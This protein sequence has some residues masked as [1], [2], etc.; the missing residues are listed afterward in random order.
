MMSINLPTPRTTS[1]IIANM[2]REAAAADGTNDSGAG[3][4]AGA[5]GANAGGGVPLGPPSS[6]TGGGGTF[7]F[8]NFI[9]SPSHGLTPKFANFATDDGTYRSFASCQPTHKDVFRSFFA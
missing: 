1:K 6:T 8:G 9:Q 5:G 3:V 7:Q 4:G 2:E